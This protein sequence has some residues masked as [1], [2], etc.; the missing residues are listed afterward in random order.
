MAEGGPSLLMRLHHYFSLLWRG[1]RSLYLRDKRPI[2][3][4]IIVTDQC[5]LECKHCAVANIKETV[6]SYQQVCGEMDRLRELGVRILFL[7]GGEPTLW[8]DEAAQKNLHDLID[9]AHRKGFYVVNLVTNGTNGFDYPQAD[10]I[11]LSIDGDEE[12]HNAVRGDTYATVLA[13]L[14]RDQPSNVCIYTAINKTN[15]SSVEAVTR[16]AAEH[17]FI[18]A[19]SYNFHTPYRG[20]EE[21]MLSREERAEIC[22]RLAKLQREG[23]PIFNLPITFETFADAT[24]EPC[25]QCVVIEDGRESVCGRCIDIPHLCENCGYLFAYEFNLLFRGNWRAIWQMFWTYRKFV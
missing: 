9:D 22:G 6:A 11:L 8:R 10:L 18:K 5:N 23:L 4:T 7:S 24:V 3:G 19:I 20:T 25:R 21:E 12:R 14:E 1:T 2:L 15:K 16:L 13:N 17:P